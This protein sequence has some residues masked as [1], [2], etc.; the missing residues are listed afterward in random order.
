MTLDL[1]MVKEVMMERSSVVD[2]LR[3]RVP[4]D[5]P[6]GSSVAVDG[7]ELGA[8]Y[9]DEFARYCALAPIFPADPSVS[10]CKQTQDVLNRMASALNACGMGVTDIVR[11]WFYLDSILDWYD[12]FNEVRT[13]FF[14]AHG[15]FDK[16]VPASTGIGASN[17]AGAAL[18]AGLIAVQPKNERVSV[19]PVDSP[20]QGSAMDYRSSFSRAVEVST[21]L[22]RTVYV[23][24]TASIDKNGGTVNINDPECQIEKTMAVVNAILESRSMGWKDVSGGVVYYPDL[25]HHELF[26][27]YC[28]TQGLPDLPLLLLESYVCRSDLLF[29]IEVDA[30]KALL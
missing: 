12:E 16:L 11:T 27:N 13:K 21:P 6:E 26:L 25:S 20:L 22:E 1:K 2:I 8:V 10:S 24:G 7:I 29:E 4:I 9:E 28:R 3:N 17:E 30:R 18:A 15:T 5:A 14:D 23:S 19:C